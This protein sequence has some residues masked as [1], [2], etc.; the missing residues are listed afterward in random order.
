MTDKN[1]RGVFKGRWLVNNRNTHSLHH[2]CEQNSLMRIKA[3]DY[4]DRYQMYNISGV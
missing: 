3:L 1:A 2:K 4:M